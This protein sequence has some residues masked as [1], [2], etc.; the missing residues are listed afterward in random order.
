MK[1]T[2]GGG[3]VN[4][5]NNKKRWS[6][7]VVAV[8]ILVFLSL[9]VPLAFLYGV[10]HHTT[11][12]GYASE[13]SGTGSSRK[14]VTLDTTSIRGGLSA[15]VDGLLKDLGPTL[16]KD[17]TRIPIKKTENKTTDF[18]VPTQVLKPPPK[19]HR[20]VSSAEGTKTVQAIGE[21][22]KMCEV[23]FGSYCLWRRQHREKM[24]DFIV[25]KMKDQLYVARAY[26]PSIAKM[27][28]LDQLSQEMKQ[29][30]QEFERIL[31]ESSSDPELPPQVEKKLLKMETTI[32]KAKAATVDCSNVD[33]KLRQLADLTEDEA[34]FHMK[35]SAFL[36]QL[37]VQ[38]T[39]KSLHCLS[40]RLTVEYFK[41]SPVDAD[42]SDS[43]TNPELYHYVLF[44]NNV[45]A[46]SVVI[47]ST[48]MHAR[49]S[50]KQVF[51]VLTDKQSYFSMK[52]WFF[53][54]AYKDATVQVLNIEDLNLPEG[55]H[56]RTHLS[57]PQELRISFLSSSE[58]RTEYISVFSD[59]H[60]A[61]PK[62]FPTLKKIVVLDDDIVV[63]RDL[64]ELC[65]LDMGGKVIGAL[66]FCA[67][68]LGAIKSYLGNEQYDVNSCTWM[69][70]LNI[71]DLGQ[72]R[73]R[74]I[75]KTYQN[76]V[77]QR[78]SETATLGATMLTFQGLLVAL[79]DKWMLS[80]LGHNYGISNEAINKAAVLHF[81]GNMKPWLELGISSHLIDKERGLQF[82][83]DKE[84]QA[85]IVL[86]RIEM[87]SDGNLKS[88]ILLFLPYYF[89]PTTT[90]GTTT[91]E[92]T[93]TTTTH[94][95][96]HH[97]SP[98]NPPPLPLLTTEPTTTTRPPDPLVAE[99][100]S[101]QA[102]SAA[103]STADRSL[104]KTPSDIIFLWKEE[105]VRLLVGSPGAST[106]PVYS[107]GSSSTSIYSPRSLA[108]PRYS[109][110]VSTPQSYSMGN[111]KNAECSNCKHLLDKITVLEATVDMYMHPEQHTVNS[112]AYF[113]KFTVI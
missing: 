57:M 13:Q 18:A 32:T 10:H 82:V 54:N 31:S 113:T 68:K 28:K 98:P 71:I 52:M 20:D 69:S 78:L 101:G 72:W 17:F 23:K 90:S 21:S 66:E 80:G 47:N 40:M 33:K 95:I 75:T 8:L 7:L 14:D 105:R 6:W 3:T 91:S 83:D 103:E 62:I 77:K 99:S 86:Y 46:S 27:P 55:G 12:T 11:L 67:V 22:D 34:N 2:G 36:Y 87:V 37:A 59:W 65:S 48:V 43:L 81:N 106:T 73:K 24:K 108:H 93:T 74:D 35:Q 49:A 41:T 70:G 9:L 4:N 96:T 38:T 92:P 111:S 16:P 63:Q 30:I 102:E 84:D 58:S 79:D 61:L 45:L 42:Q 53:T 97:Y 100:T 88:R 51:H 26:Y 107:P 60:Y 64:S 39:P 76:L 29:N 25:K 44:S 112:A 50:G 109:P 89:S 19:K 5:N 1:P 94:H 15:R 56:D 85:A 104:S 110:R